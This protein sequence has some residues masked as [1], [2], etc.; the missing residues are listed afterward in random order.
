MMAAATDDFQALS[1]R[2]LHLEAEL[3]DVL[4]RPDAADIVQTVQRYE[5]D[6]LQATLS[7]QAVRGAVAN[8]RF[9]WQHE[10][11]EGHTCG[12][13]SGIS[14]CGHGST[15]PTE[16][17]IKG[18]TQESYQLLEESVSAINEAI[19]EMQQLRTE[20]LEES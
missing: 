5:R 17:D 9:S 20:L 3:R 4:H 16:A 18:A 19:T 2:A 1:L 14:G 8:Q 13:C 6:K 10:G 15:E 7:L 11:G 12:A